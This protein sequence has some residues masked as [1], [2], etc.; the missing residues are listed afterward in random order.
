MK[1]WVD[2]SNRENISRPPGKPAGVETVVEGT[3]VAVGT[4]EVSEGTTEV[5]ETA[6]SVGGGPDVTTA[7]S[8]AHATNAS[9]SPTAKT[10][11]ERTVWYG[12]D[13][14]TRI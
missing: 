11:P 3:V 5:D 7:S 4:T 14:M 13:V 6:D 10:M 8:T 2:S 1:V 12:G 9:A